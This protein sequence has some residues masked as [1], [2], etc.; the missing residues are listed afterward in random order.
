MAKTI[1]EI[2]TDLGGN[3]TIEYFDDTTSKYNI[4]NTL[5][6]TDTSVTVGGVDPTDGQKLSF[7][8]NFGIVP[9]SPLGFPSQISRP[10]FVPSR[11]I[12]SGSDGVNIAGGWSVTNGTLV[13]DLTN[14]R[15]NATPV[16]KATANAGLVEM[17]IRKKVPAVAL[18]SGLELFVKVPRPTVGTISILLQ[19]SAS[20][21]ASDPPTSSVANGRQMFLSGGEYAQGG[22]SGV[23][24][25]PA[26]SHY[27]TGRPQGR[28][29]YST[30]ALPS[31]VNYIDIV[32]QF[33]ADVPA[34]ERDCYIDSIAINGYVKPLVVIGF[35]GFY[36][37]TASVAL[38][39]FKKY[40]IKG[41]NSSS[42][43]NISANKATCDLLYAAGWDL[44]S[45][46]QRSAD[47]GLDSSLLSADIDS[48]RIQ[49]DAAGY[50]RG[51]NIFTYPFN[52]RSAATDA[53]LISKG[54]T[55]ARANGDAGFVNS[56]VG[57]GGLM[58]VGGSTL[59]NVTAAQAQATIDASITQGSHAFFYGHDLV[60]T[61]T[62][63]STQM[64]S[65]EFATFLAYAAD[66]H[67]SGQIEIVT[68][69][70]F[71][72]RIY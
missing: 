68:P 12:A 25:H 9:L 40:G 16:L 27:G 55:C 19:W 18:T 69:S 57:N 51:R 54:F 52:S 23:K 72:S 59:N 50:V 53:I 42:G 7:K 5:I 45:Q 34:A 24:M 38:P 58:S 17:V 30:E 28:A 63:T 56:Q 64:L 65:T 46:A 47:Y 70:E 29:W 71:L 15:I 39:L 35:D 32:F 8:N 3:T 33:S 44:I 36:S 14:S 6:S 11:V 26:I 66:K 43:N 48:A 4:A 37:S 62:S 41:Y 13:S 2:Y 1:K 10:S 31:I 60:N 21:P 49:Y 22:W 20:V 67:F 61:I